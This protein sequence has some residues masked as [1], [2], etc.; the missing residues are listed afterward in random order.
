MGT[1]LCGSFEGRPVAFNLRVW[2]PLLLAPMSVT[3][4]QTQ[5][6]LSQAG[7]STVFCCACA[8]VTKM[9]TASITKAL[10][11]KKTENAFFGT[12]IY[13]KVIIFR[14]NVKEELL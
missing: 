8:G 14:L 6:E 5:M 13:Y 11:L 10:K 7:A 3:L 12:C 9:R 1:P 2:K 4:G